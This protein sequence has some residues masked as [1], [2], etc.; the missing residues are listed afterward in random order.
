[1]TPSHIFG[2]WLLTTIMKML[3]GTPF[4]DSQSGMWIFKRYIWDKLYVYSSGMAFSQE[5][6]IEAHIRGFTCAEVPIKY[7]ARAGETKLNTVR[8]GMKTVTHL[9]YKKFSLLFSTTKTADKKQFA[10]K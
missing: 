10:V 7:R 2:N 8:D 5:L 9:F 4:T 1:M 6:K 3:F